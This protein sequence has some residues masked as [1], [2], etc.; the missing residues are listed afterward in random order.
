MSENKK[1]LLLLNLSMILF[2]FVGLLGRSIQLNPAFITFGRAF[3][4][5]ISLL[6]IML[7]K[8]MPIRLHARKDYV[9]M[10]IL[11]LLIVID[12][13]AMFQSLK[14]SSVA[15]MTISFS[16]F[17]IIVAL[18]DPIFF[19]EKF[20]WKN[21]I[22]AAM[23]ILGMVIMIPRFDV[24]NSIAQGILWG[25]TS[26]IAFAFILML[27]KK[28]VREYPTTTLAFYENLGVIVILFPF[29]FFQSPQNFRSVDI[30]FLILLGVF[31][32]GIAHSLLIK[33]LSTIK[34]ETASI[35][36]NTEI[37]Y[38]ITLAAIILKETPNQRT[39]LGIVVI[40]GTAI[41]ATTSNLFQKEKKESLSLTETEK[42]RLHPATTRHVKLF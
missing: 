20:A 2:S 28:Y 17:P 30:G 9:R 27:D 38:A 23:T 31:C 14:V 22:F 21:L 24:G 13:T 29:L 12:W 7:W 11:S 36:Q 33:S 1:N 41:L 5:A 6:M 4:A 16:S 25:V 35:L 37:I 8:K 34:A 15:V 39:L 40:L 3:F 42:I 18:F 19:H 26:G 32:T 10:M